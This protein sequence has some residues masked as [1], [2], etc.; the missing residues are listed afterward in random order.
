MIKQGISSFGMKFLKVRIISLHFRQHN[1]KNYTSFSI[2]IK[3]TILRTA[4]QS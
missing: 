1:L 2:I 3:N 4:Q